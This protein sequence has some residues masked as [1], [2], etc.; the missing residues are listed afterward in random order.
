MN[1]DRT[2]PFPTRTAWFAPVL[3][4]AAALF[5][6]PGARGGPFPAA[7]PDGPVLRVQVVYPG[8]RAPASIEARRLAAGMGE[9]FVSSADAALIFRA[10]RFWDPDRL[11]LTMRAGGRSVVATVNSR[12]V[13][14]AGGNLLLALAPVHVDGD[15]WLPLEF[16]TAVLAPAA[17]DDVDWDPV[18]QTLTVGGR[19]ADLL[20]LTLASSTDATTLTLGCAKAL[21]WRLERTAPDTLALTLDDASAAPALLGAVAADGLV[22]GGLLAQQPGGVRIAVALGVRA[23]GW[24]VET[25]DDGREIRLALQAREGGALEEPVPAN[26]APGA[27][28][29]APSRDV[30]VVVV[31]PGHGGSD[32][33]AIGDSGTPEKDLMLDLARDLR[34]QLRRLDFD[35][36]LTRDDDRD[37]EPEQ[38][39]EAANRS[40]GDVFVSLHADSWFGAEASGVTTFA[41]VADDAP[42]PD[43]AD[44]FTPWHLAQRRHAVASG[45]L[46]ALVQ[47]RLVAASGSPDRGIVR[48]DARILQGVD[49]PAV[50]IEVGF[51]T[52]PGQESRLL[53]GDRRR[54][55]AAA[56]AAAVDAFRGAEDRDAARPASRREEPW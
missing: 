40:D 41:A 21:A 43:L 27:A 54:E 46:A 47:P 44:G 14:S 37:L 20:T 49:M 28:A 22:A 12:H 6:A 30:R 10:A 19:R 18:L 9:P 2:C 1:A 33:G 48:L 55:L 7:D 11:Q 45:E 24:N 34:Q 53:D 56:I 39:A 51:L 38:R 4:V 42:L 8:D 26:M 31:D 3:M 5:I 25:A 17:G 29:A 13:Q 32:R 50:M 23:G 36:V 52:D 15:V 16:L 35:V